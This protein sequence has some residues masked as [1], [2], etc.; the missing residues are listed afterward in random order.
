V[1]APLRVLLNTVTFTGS[2]LEVAYGSQNLSPVIDGT[3]PRRS[4]EAAACL[5]REALGN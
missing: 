3:D 5:S 1:S 4:P 2:P